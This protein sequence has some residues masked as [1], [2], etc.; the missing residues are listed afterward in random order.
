MNRWLLV[1]IV[2]VTGMLAGCLPSPIGDPATSTVDPTLEGTWLHDD[3][4]LAQCQIGG[5]E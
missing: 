1:A 4:K 5:V 2:L 3:S